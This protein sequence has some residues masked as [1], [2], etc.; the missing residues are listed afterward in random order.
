MPSHRAAR[1]AG[2]RRGQAPATQIGIRGSCRGRGKKVASSMRKCFPSNEK[3]SPDHRPVT[4][5]SAS[6]SFSARTRGSG[7]SPSAE[8]SER[9][10]P[11]SPTPR[12]RRPPE[13]RSSVTVSRATFAGR[14]R[15]RGVTSGPMRIRSVAAAIA[16]RA[17]QGSATSQGSPRGSREMWSQTKKPSQPAS[18]VSLASWARSRASANSRAIGR[19]IPNLTPGPP[20]PE[21]DAWRWRAA[22]PRG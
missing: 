5:S 10:S 1:R 11:P 21:D 13:R 20:R 22:R 17:I 14:R 12:T 2:P 9:S 18:S 6:S 16:L 15:A 7:S 4:T 3:G 8:K 19:Y